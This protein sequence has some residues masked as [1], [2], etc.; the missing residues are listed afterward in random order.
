MKHKN[1]KKLTAMRAYRFSPGLAH[2]VYATARS[3]NLSESEFVRVVLL[4]AVGRL[5]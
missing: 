4:D 3:L 2:S 5:N 1:S